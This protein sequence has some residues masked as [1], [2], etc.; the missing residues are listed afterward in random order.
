[1]PSLRDVAEQ[2]GVSVSTASIALRHD[3]RVKESTRRRVLSVAEEIGYRPNGAARDLKSRRTGMIAILLHDLGGPFYSE[4]LRGVSTRA[5]ANG[6]TALVCT[7]ALDRG[8]ELTRLLREKR[9]DGAII[10]D[11]SISEDDILEVASPSL[12]L[13]LLD[14]QIQHP[15]LYS[16]LCD[17]RS[18][19]Y[20]ATLHLIDAGYRDIGIILGPSDSH[21]SHLREEGALQ[22]CRLRQCVPRP[23]HIWHGAFT[24]SSGYQLV[25]SVLASDDVPRAIF[26]ANDEMAVGLMRGLLERGVRIP[27]D[28]ALA[29]FDDIRITQYVSPPLTTVRQ[30][31]YELGILAADTLM[32]ALRGDEDITPIVL[33]TELVVRGSS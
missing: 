19:A 27:D 22:A 20:M 10:L 15:N 21:H 16:V 9:V 25:D 31:M 32:R 18:G 3:T 14:R 17:H 33:Q 7:S 23:D 1:M 24:E 4:L 8:G 30:P 2:A 6:L 29:G 5:Q 26:V 13:I 12:P 28:V 11:S